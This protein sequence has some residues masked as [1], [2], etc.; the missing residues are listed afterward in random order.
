MR[1]SALGEVGSCPMKTHCASETAL[2]FHARPC[3]DKL[4][5]ASNEQLACACAHKPTRHRA[6]SL[7]RRRS[8]RAPRYAG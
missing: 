6:L 8:T 3:S 1:R 4:A 7:W 5:S 2:L